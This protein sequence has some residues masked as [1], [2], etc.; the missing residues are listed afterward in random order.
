MQRSV[1]DMVTTSLSHQV[2]SK[3]SI[4]EIEWNFPNSFVLKDVYV[5]DKNCDTMLFMDRTKVTINL[6]RLLSSQISFRTIQFTGLEANLS[7]DSTQ[8]PNFQFFIDAFKSDNND[9]LSLKWTMDIESFAFEGCQIS[10]KNPYIEENLIGRF[11]PN[12]VRLYDIN[13]CLYVRTYDEDSLNIK[14]DNISF[15]EQS[16]FVVDDIS[17]VVALNDENINLTKFVLKTPNSSLEIKKSILYHQHYEALKRPQELLRGAVQF[18]PSV[19]K[20]SDFSVFHPALD[21]LQEPFTIDGEIYGSLS[22]IQAN[23]LM[24]KYGKSTCIAGNVAVR[25]LYPDSK[26]MNLVA[27]VEKISSNYSELSDLLWVALDRDIQLPKTLDSLGVISYRG[28]LNGDLSNMLSEGM[29]LSNMGTLNVSVAMN[30]QDLQLNSYTVEGKVNTK[31]CHLNKVFGDASHLGNVA[32]NAEIILHKLADRNFRLKALGA[33]DSFYYKNYCYENI[34]LDGNFDNSGF[35]GKLIMS[36]PNAELSF[37]GKADLRKENPL[38]HFSSNVRDFNLTKTHLM[39]GVD[40]THLSFDVETNFVGNNLDDLEGSFS[41]DNVIFSQGEKELS[42]SNLSISASVLP[43]ENKKLSVYSDYI[44][45]Y[46]K[47]KYALT[48]LPAFFHNIAH[49]YLPAVVKDEKK[50]VS[51]NGRINNFSYDFSIENLEPI[52][53]VYPMPIV[54]EDEAKLKGFVNELTHKFRVRL[55]APY[56]KKGGATLQN[57]VF[58]CENPYDQL[59]LMC[60]MDYHPKNTS[61]RPYYLSLNTDAKNNDVNVN[62]NFSNSVEE[63]Y[64]GKVKL[65]TL[66]KDYVKGEGLTADIHISPSHIILNDTIWTIKESTIALDKKWISVDSFIFSHGTQFLYVNGVNSSVASDSINV[67]F[68]D[69]YL[70]YISDIIANDDISFNG[71]AD[72]DVFVFK[73]F[74]MPYFKGDLYVYDSEINECVLGDM[75]IVSAWKDREKCIDFNAELL[76]PYRDNTNLSKSKLHG[77]VFLGND[78]LYIGGKLKD[79]SMGF[80][81]KYLK[82]VL[83]N[84]TGTV[85]GDIAAYGK[86]GNIGLEG[87]TYVKDMAFDVDFLKTSFVL[88]DSVKLTPHTIELNQTQLYDTEGHYG[89]ISGMLL[90]DAFRN[91]KFAFD[92]DCNNLLVMNTKEEDNETFYGKAYAKGKAHFSGTPETVNIELAMKTMPN[93]MMIIPIEGVSS[94]KDGNFVTFVESEENKTMQEKRRLRR[95]KIKQINEQKTKT[96]TNI[97]LVVDLEATPDAQVHMIMDQQQGDVIRANGAGSLRLLYNLKENDFKMYGG[98]EIEKGDYLFTIQS[99]ISRKFDII[100]GSTVQ[101]TGSPYQADINIKAKYSLNASLSD[102]IDDP[103]IASNTTM[104]NCLMNLTGTITSPTIKFDIELP[105]SDDDV[106]SQLKSQINTEEAMNRN[107]ASLMALGHFYNLDK[108]VEA[109]TEL[110]SVGFSTL[111]SQLSNWISKMTQ[112]V[113]IGFNYRPTSTGADGTVTSSE[114]DVA[115]STQFLNDRLILNG[116]FGYRDEV[117]DAENI[118]NSIVDFDIEYKLNKSGKF[119]TKGFNRSNNSY[120]KQSP[121]TQGLGVVYREEFDT[122]SG[123]LKSYWNALK[124]DEEKEKNKKEGK[125]EKKK[126]KKE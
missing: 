106:R 42:M 125:K 6:W 108:S 62:F 7:V 73:L 30:S 26:K 103:M 46:I 21:L 116:N 28:T 50:V 68:S 56:V 16:G 1:V 5:E 36:D 34:R 94:V 52:Y 104:V 54:V 89:V 25:N 22:H 13:G 75:S 9:T 92:L 69:L 85:S 19:I 91:I 18:S 59:K 102:I 8:V 79:V 120:F 32:F 121:N 77:G 48:T 45:G 115:L 111:S 49:Q 39:E 82:N 4:E 2:G 47:G 61:R 93:T 51:K 95:E 43:G 122:F 117:E 123:L 12:D 11:N 84:N 20:L 97:Q 78:S 80:L 90:H 3:V 58:L 114:F 15:K 105:N 17:T 107:I 118:S 83:Q 63:T 72:G 100:S 81:R 101:W 53:D 41:L 44:N 126:D 124:R 14:V 86:F 55:E 35:D 71:V 37:I 66:F 74:D 57:L 24:M 29:I 98:Y 23:G 88:S 27:N 33:V 65:E 87:M 67:H 70:G 64:S 110:S 38:Y 96:S 60:R 76:S 109:T 40:D 119:R 112:D 99:I 31:D 10:Y 113:N